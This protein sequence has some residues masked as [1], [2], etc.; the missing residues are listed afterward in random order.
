MGI[1]YLG[2]NENV[3][4][5]YFDHRSK[6][7]EMARTILTF[8]ASV[9]ATF[10]LTKEVCYDKVGCFDNKWPWRSL[11]RINGTLPESPEKINATFWLVAENGVA[12][13]IIL[14]NTESIKSSEFNVNHPTKIL[15]HGFSTSANTSMSCKSLVKPIKQAENG[16]A[17]VICLNW[18]DG[19]FAGRFG[20]RYEQAT[21]NTRL[22]GRLLGQFLL[23]LKNYGQSPDQFHLIGH[24]LGAH[25]AGYAGK[26]YSHYKNARDKKIARISGLDPAGPLFD[27]SHRQKDV[28]DDRFFKDIHLTKDDAEFVD[29]IH[30]DGKPLIPGIGCGTL[31]SWGHVDFFPNGGYEQPGCWD[32]VDPFDDILPRFQVCDHD[33]AIELFISSISNTGWYFLK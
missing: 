22:V 9:S 32:S 18:R 30:T 5:K 3:L 6:I 29:N 26:Y 19:S 20:L 10:N 33:R 23:F 21:A 28:I 8:F 27:A 15:I 13:E 24:S 17:N 7:R 2:D 14:N 11:S 12:K 25:I 31:K 16:N 1:V 4:S